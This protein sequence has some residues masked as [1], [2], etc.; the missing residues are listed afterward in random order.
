[1]FT[2]SDPSTPHITLA[3]VLTL[4]AAAE[5]LATQPD[6]AALEVRVHR[7]GASRPLDAD[8]TATLAILTA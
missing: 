5:A 4:E 6:P 2:V 3:V 7:D 8:E 1:M